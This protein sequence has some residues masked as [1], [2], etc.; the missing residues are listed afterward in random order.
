[1]ANYGSKSVLIKGLSDKRNITLTFTIT[2]A[3][4]FLSIQI[5][6]GGKT[7]KSQPRGFKFPS[8]FLVSQN[9]KHWSNEEETM[10]LIDKIITPY[11]VKKREELQLP[12]T[13]K[14]LVIWDVFRGQVTNKVLR[15]LDP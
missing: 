8:W 4:E 5:I 2:L 15:K 12:V 10:K 9:P 11:I 1:M 13:Q 7:Q 6:Y 14:A 3:G